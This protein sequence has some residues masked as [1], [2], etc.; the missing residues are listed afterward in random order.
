MMK[1]VLFRGVGFQILF[2]VVLWAQS[3]TKY[4]R[5]YTDFVRSVDVSPTQVIG[6]PF[7]RAQY[8]QNRVRQLDYILAHGEL[9][10]RTY[11]TYDRNLNLVRSE[12]YTADSTLLT[13]SSFIPDEIQKQMLSKVQG[14]NWISLQKNY[15]TITYFDSTQKP[16][17]HVVKAASGEDIGR[18]ELRYNEQGA[19][20]YEI[21]IRNRDNKVMSVSEFAYDAEQS[22]Q[23]IV[24][25]D[26]S[27]FEISNV[28]LKLPATPGD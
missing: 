20:Q 14:R 12:Q 5:N 13:S 24:Q 11:F 16:I 4:F 17:K 1:K 10:M 21:W 28:S 9:S 22:I 8:D 2:M 6:K 25:Y 27:G 19:L 18:L 3:G 7:Y 15:F 23:H 26:S